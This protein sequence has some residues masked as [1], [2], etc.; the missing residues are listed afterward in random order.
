MVS[1]ANRAVVNRSIVGVTRTAGCGRSS[2]ALRTP[3]SVRTATG[4]GPASGWD[5]AKTHVYGRGGGGGGA[6]KERNTSYMKP[7]VFPGSACF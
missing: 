4:R 5:P 6:K 3:S 1:G 2:A 7:R